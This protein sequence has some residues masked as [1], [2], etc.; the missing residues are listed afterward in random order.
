M[1]AQHVTRWVESTAASS[2]KPQA[3]RIE[4]R[5]LEAKG[6]DSAGG[7]IFRVRVIAYG[8]SKN[9][10]R[11]P[12]SVLRAAVGLYQG[13]RAY[14]HHRDD[15]ALRSSTIAGLVGSYRNVVATGRGL[16]A[17]LH[18]LPSAT[19]A[20]EALDASLAAQAEGLPPLAGVSHDV[21]ATYR[22]IADGARRLAE[23]TA[24]VKVNSAD[25]VA[26]PAAGGQAVRMVAGGIDDGTEPD[27]LLHDRGTARGRAVVA[28][29][30]TA[31]GLPD[32]CVD[33][34]T[35]TLPERFSEAQLGAAIDAAL[36]LIA[37]TE[38]AGLV[39]TVGA[40][41]TRE[42]LEKKTA[43]LDAFFTTDGTPG[44]Y[45]SLREAYL[46]ITGH[47]ARFLDED[48]NRRILR[49]SY[50]TGFDSAARGSESLA[51]A[52]W[53]QVLGD[54]VTRRLVAEYG[55]PAWQDWRR[56]VSA[57]VFGTDFRT[58]RRARFGGYGLLP[59]VNEA[60]PY[61][62]LT[63]PPDEEAT[64]KLTKR[65][66]TEDITLEMIANDDIEAIR[67]IPIR[68]GRSAAT[69]LYRFVFDIL[70]TN[71]AVSYDATALFHASHAN[72]DNPAPLGQSTLSTGRRK[73]RKQSAYGDSADVLSIV[74]RYLIVP[75]DLEELAFQLCTSVV[76][77][78]ATPAGPSDTPNIHR[79]MEPITVDYYTDS[80]D[81]YLIADPIQTPTI[82]IG[83]Y[84]SQDAPELFTQADQ[85]TGSMFDADKLIYKIRH[86]Y[87][88][89]VVDHRGF[90]R[91]AN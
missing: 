25:V 76:A 79:G 7:R 8:D 55:R 36:A 32:Q 1:I 43:A 34:L 33:Q 9:G 3:D 69:T 17:D 58:Q 22:P 13:A 80:N 42:A 4:G 28:Q 16:E 14:D 72:T 75:A 89:T 70:P 57:I 27:E 52:S 38:R 5:V 90:Y 53:A 30:A 35:A 62:P 10:R 48:L 40:R 6:T 24:I 50:G 74:P 66:G 31:R 67:R 91:G 78:P 2:P 19:H 81:W 37:A 82:E 11:Y 47:R 46:D 26:E 64:Y 20:A 29:E 59:A 71:A 85:N 73:M 87:S 12:E 45:R 84:A 60:A 23:A 77:V 63:S 65:G 68:L 83:F 86:I 88:G 44:G 56:V 61:Q 21:L 54:S 49:D 39:P 41:V 51:E 15:A 18:L